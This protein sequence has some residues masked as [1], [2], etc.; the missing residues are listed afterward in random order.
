MSKKL[1]IIPCGQGKIW[2]ATPD[3]GPVQA[4]NAYTGAPFKVNREYAQRFADRW[5]ILSAKYGFIDP[6]FIIP[7]PYN[8]TF[9]RRS[10]ELVTLD[11]LKQQA[12]SMGL[13]AFKEIIGLG[14]QEY[15]AMIHMVFQDAGAT[16]IFPFAGL[17]LGEGMAAIKQ[18]LYLDQAVPTDNATRKI[19]AEKPAVKSHIRSKTALHQGDVDPLPS[20]DDFRDAIRSKFEAANRE[21]KQFIDIVSGDLHRQLGGYPGR[22]HKM[23]SCCSVMKSLMKAGDLVVDQPPSGKGATLKIRYAIPR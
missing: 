2:D 9:K 8:V 18:A 10:P 23:V 1:V 20:V 21:G 15:R 12:S 4:A 14:G 11:I 19:V 13:N 5:I 22:N 3:A 7:G 17:A 6:D 16:I